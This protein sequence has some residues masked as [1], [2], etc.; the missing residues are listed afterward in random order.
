MYRTFAVLTTWNISLHT[1]AQSHGPKLTV[2]TE[3]SI[4][5]LYAIKSRKLSDQ[6]TKVLNVLASG[7]YPATSDTAAE[8]VI[9]LNSLCPPLTQEEDAEAY[10][11]VVWDMFLLIARSP[12]VACEVHVPLV[13]IIQLLENFAKGS[14]TI[15]GV[16]LSS[17]PF[18][19]TLALT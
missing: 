14:V 15:W 1:F 9:Q 11:W 19:R 4:F 16:K 5:E 10:I 17:T 6:Q 7:I 12:D 8:T 2:G 13:N 3:G 18:S